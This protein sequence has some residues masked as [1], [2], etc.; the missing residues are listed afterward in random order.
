[1]P[2]RWCNQAELRSHQIESGLDLTFSEVFLP[3]FF[4]K[5]RTFRP[6]KAL[7]VGAGTG[8]LSLAMKA[9]IV[10]LTAIEPSMGMFKEAVRVLEGSDVRVLN[11]TAQELPRDI[12]YDLCISHLVAHVV[13]DLS[14]FLTSIREV[15][16]SNGH[17]VFSLPH[18]CFYNDYKRLFSDDEYMYMREQSKEISFSITNDPDNRI[19]RVPYHHRPLSSYFSAIR[20]AGLFVSEFEE[21]FPPRETQEKYGALWQAPRYCLFICGVR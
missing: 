18:P 6:E 20:N 15:L 14:G 19:E 11:C 5:L 2:R 3:L 13:D 21:V 17:L 9:E 12:V 8:H 1:M 7:E 4:G 16:D 10:D